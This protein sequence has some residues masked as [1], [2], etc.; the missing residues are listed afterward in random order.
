M[1]ARSASVSG[2]ASGSRR[3]AASTSASFIGANGGTTTT[4]SVPS[5]L[6]RTSVPSG[7]SLL[8]IVDVLLMF[9]GSTRRDDPDIVVSF[10]VDHVQYL[11][12]R[13]TEK[14][15]ALFAVI[16]PIVNPLDV[17]LVREC[18]RRLIKGHAV[19]LAD[20]ARRL[21][22]V[23]F[24]CDCHDIVRLSSSSVKCR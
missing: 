9:V 3:A 20:V 18:E 8:T 10:G 21:F 23:P 7:R 6:T 4:S 24:E 15:T 13:Q 17:K 1:R 11:A 19:M 2:R 12:L 22:F 16:L 5:G 14:N